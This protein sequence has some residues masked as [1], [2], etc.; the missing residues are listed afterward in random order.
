VS[1]VAP[2]SLVGTV[3]QL[4]GGGLDLHALV[5]AG[6]DRAERLD[7]LLH[8]LLPEPGRRQRLHAA[9][10]ALLRAY[11]EPASRPP[12]FGVLVGVKDVLRVEGLPTA[13][14]SDLPPERLDGA[15]SPAVAALR[16][17]G[18]LVMGKTVTAELAYAA[19]GPTRNPH[20]PARTPG[21]S[22]HGSAAGVAAGLFPLALGTQTI[23]SVMRPAAYCGVAG[24]VP[25]FGRIPAGGLLAVSRTL[26]RVGL[27]AADVPSLTLAASTLVRRWRV[28]GGPRRPALGVA[29]GPFLDHAEPAARE[30]FERQVEA[31]AAAGYRVRRV[32]LFEDAEAVTGSLR[33]L[34]NGELAREHAE[35]FERHRDRYRPQTAAGIRAGLLLDERQLLA[36]R[37]AALER[38]RQVEARRR[39]AAVD[40][41]LSPA[42]CG[43]APAGIASS[44]SPWLSVPWS[45]VGL[46]AVALPAGTVGDL[47]V[48]LQLVAGWEADE[49][50]LS[51]CAGISRAVGHPAAPA[52]P[53]EAPGEPFAWY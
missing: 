50:L 22:S 6:C 23:A 48:G 42:A 12:L 32:R 13:G 41:W 8:A 11:P 27:F 30:L 49:Q 3:S 15:E 14:G 9:A 28:A 34:V 24:Y 53:D 44:G 19:P 31:L 39:S 18:A 25:T 40:V 51:W 5:D 29:E 43:P 10:G 46:P 20:D 17:A 16:A 37:R 21:G 45:Y 7:P 33:R 35:L 1:N 36:D 47:P 26:D 2:M 38:R 4:R 52:P